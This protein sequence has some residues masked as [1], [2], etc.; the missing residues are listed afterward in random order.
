MAEAARR[1][2]VSS[3]APY[4]HYDSLDELV[5][6]TAEAAYERFRQRQEGL[7]AGLAGC[8]AH[9]TL[10]ALVRDYFAFAIEE[11]GAVRLIF[12]ARLASRDPVLHPMANDDFE[13]V[14]GLVAQVVGERPEDCREL[15]LTI[16]A[17]VLGQVQL[18]VEQFSPVSTL[19]EAPE[20][21][22]TGVDLL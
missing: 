16:S 8:D 2:G 1:A 7:L 22:A 14:R 20:L 6:A 21:A 18:H 11:R 19:G 13:L 12:D 10:M 3:G 15:A 4:R 9:T 17:V 5:T